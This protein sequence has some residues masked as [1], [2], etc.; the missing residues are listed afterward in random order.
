MAMREYVMPRMPAAIGN[1]EILSDITR[2]AGTTA[3][4]TGVSYVVGRLMKDKKDNQAARAVQTGVWAGLLLDVAGT[5]IK[6]VTRKTDGLSLTAGPVRAPLTPRQIGLNLL[7]M[8]SISDAFYQHKLAS[9]LKTANIVV[10]GSDNGQVALVH[11]T[12]GEILMAGPVK[13]VQ[14]VITALNGAAVSDS[15]SGY[16]E[17]ITVES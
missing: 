10:A 9:T 8:G 5:A 16:G 17:D 4:A 15:K 7:G 11:G 2:I 13:Q 14:P 1:N 3:L 12:T 6:Y